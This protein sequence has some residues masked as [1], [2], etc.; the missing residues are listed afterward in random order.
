MKTKALVEK[1]FEFDRIRIHIRVKSD[2]ITPEEEP[3]PFLN[4]NGSW[5]ITVDIDTGRIREWPTGQGPFDIY[6]KPVDTGVY[7]L[8][9]K[10]QSEPAYKLSGYVPHGIIPGEFGDYVDLQINEDG[11]I[12]NWPKSPDVSALTDIGD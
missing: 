11:V 3:L 1:E 5:D 8:F 6:A 9:K 10:G 7:Q 12:T 2:D 4:E